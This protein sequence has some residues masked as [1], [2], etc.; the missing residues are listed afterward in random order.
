MANRKKRV[1]EFNQV[2]IS[3]DAH[4][5]ADLKCVKVRRSIELVHCHNLLT[6][7]TYL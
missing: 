7:G 2:G 1:E 5:I 4:V 3:V 6:S